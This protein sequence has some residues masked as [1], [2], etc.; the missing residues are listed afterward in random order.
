ME[1]RADRWVADVCGIVPRATVGLL[2]R[3]TS[4]GAAPTALASHPAG[5]DLPAGLHSLVQSALVDGRPAF[6]QRALT[7]VNHGRSTAIAVAFP[8]RTQGEPAAPRT[9][10]WD[11][12]V[13]VLEVV[14]AKREEVPGILERIRAS[15]PWLDVIEAA[16]REQ[17]RLAQIVSL[18][19]FLLEQNDHAGAVRALA[20]ELAA[21]L[22][23][24]RVSVGLVGDGRNRIVAVSHAARFDAR[25]QRM[26][27][28]ATVMDE[29]TDQDVA[30]AWP[31]TPAGPACVAREHETYGRRREISRLYTVPMASEGCSIGAVTFEWTDGDTARRPGLVECEDLVALLSPLLERIRLSGASPWERVRSSAREHLE[32][33]VGPGA[34][35]TKC[36][37]ALA[38]VAI[39]V[40]LLFDGQWRVTADATLEGRSQRAIVA[41]LDG[42]LAQVDASPGDVVRQGQLLAQLDDAD[43][44]LELRRWE[45]RR[46]EQ[47]KEYREALANHD[48]AQM[49]ILGARIGQADAQV[50]LL[51]SRLAHTRLVA[52]FEGVV[53]RG[54]HRQ[55]LGSPVEKG[56]ILF[57]LAPLDGYRVMLEVDERDVSDIAAGQTGELALSALPHERLSLTVDRVTPVATARDGSNVFR[58]E[59]RLDK[60]SAALRPGMSGVAKVDVERRSLLWIWT[61]DLVDR[62]QLWLWLWRP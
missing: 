3:C 4:P 62:V 21:R 22:R 27:E 41:G 45:A 39:L 59:A 52:P 53:V 29:A 19:A 38:V 25:S 37:V 50:E 2:V 43:L 56:Q 40:G 34:V 55:S 46:A 60:P 30:I 18:F 6:Q 28:L 33:L 23:C 58:V 51:E 61:H 35:R 14:D 8:P 7:R 24:D 36:V 5:T 48:R 47:E 31:G 32:T 15:L 49:S 54:D 57:E 20:A 44:G 11:G 9:E 13:L 42:F 1:T 26:R 16:E 17:Q 12:R 10:R